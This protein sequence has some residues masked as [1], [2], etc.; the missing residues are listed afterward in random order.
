MSDTSE[1]P[2]WWQ[3][4]DGKWYRPEQHPNYLPPPPPQVTGIAVAPYPGAAHPY[5]YEGARRT[6]GLAVASLVLSIVWLGGVGSLLAIIF[7]F[8]ARRQIRESA[9]KQGGDGLAI[10]GLVIGI[11]GLLLSVLAWGLILA[12]GS[13]VEK[14]TSNQVAY[15]NADAASVE[16]ALQAYQAQNNDSYPPL[17]APWSAASYT[18]NYSLLTTANSNGGPWLRVAPSTS[19]YV[20]EYD[21]S[22]HVWVNSSGDFSVYNPAHAFS[23]DTNVCSAP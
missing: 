16:T 18:T 19:N 17:L 22:G 21:G 20:I 12:V 1:G 2:G 5:P 14:A 4:S 7:G 11:I 3:A 9:G 23:P 8:Q 6:N 13:V 10:A 15:C